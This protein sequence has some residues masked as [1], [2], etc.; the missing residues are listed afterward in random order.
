M[1]LETARADT[2]RSVAFRMSEWDENHYP[3]KQRRKKCFAKF[4]TN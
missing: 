2:V 3:A 1:R 4:D